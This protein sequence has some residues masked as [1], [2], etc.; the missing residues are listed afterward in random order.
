[1]YVIRYRNVITYNLKHFDPETCLRRQYVVGRNNTGGSEQS[2]AV[3][4]DPV[5]G[6]YNIMYTVDVRPTAAVG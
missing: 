3:A 5:F 6:R 4:D 1:M 2:A